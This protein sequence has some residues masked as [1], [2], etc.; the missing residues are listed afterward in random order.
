[1]KKAKQKS[2]NSTSKKYDLHLAI[3]QIYELVHE[4]E[5]KRKKTKTIVNTTAFTI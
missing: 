4:N 2:V 5:P 3:S 1:M